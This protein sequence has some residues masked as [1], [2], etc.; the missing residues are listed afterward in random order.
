MVKPASLH[1][2]RSSTPSSALEHSTA[3]RLPQRFHTRVQNTVTT[4]DTGGCSARQ[5]VFAVCGYT[6][7]ADPLSGA[8]GSYAGSHAFRASRGWGVGPRRKP[9]SRHAARASSFFAVVY[10]YTTAF[11]IILLSMICNHCAIISSSCSRACGSHNYSELQAVAPQRGYANYNRAAA[12]GADRP[13]SAY[14]GL[15]PTVG[16]TMV[17]SRGIGAPL[18]QP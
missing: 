13:V 12:L 16:W 6:Y 9:A 11:A 2:L 7:N 15:G 1:V 3:R 10:I 17:R 18:T 8:H 14:V 4:V 5:S